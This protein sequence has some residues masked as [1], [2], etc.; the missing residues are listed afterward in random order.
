LLLALAVAAPSW[1]LAKERLV[2]RMGEERGLAVPNVVALGQDERG[3]IWIGTASCLQRHD[4]QELR[5]WARDTLIGSVGLIAAGTHDDVYVAAHPG[6]L[7]RLTA[8]SAVAV[9]GPPGATLTEISDLAFDGAGRLWVI[10]TAG[11]FRLNTDGSWSTPLAGQLA[12]ERARR[13]AF[14]ADGAAFIVTLRGLWRIDNSD[15]ASRLADMPLA[16]FNAPM[17]AV[18]GPGG[19]LFVSTWFGQIF[20]YRGGLVERIAVGG[21]ARALAVR[22]DAVWAALDGH[23]VALYPD[24]PPELL[25][26]ERGIS[27]AGEA[28]LVD[29][30]GSLWVGNTRGLFQF[31]EPETAAWNSGDGLPDAGPID[32]AVTSEGVWSIHWAYQSGFIDTTASPHAASEI[33]APSLVG[34]LCV[35]GHGRLWGVRR[36]EAPG[37]GVIVSRRD[38]T[39]IDHAGS[40]G[41]A[42]CAG[43]RAG[44]VWFTSRRGLFVSGG[45]DDPLQA[46]GMPRT[47]QGELWAR[48]IYE[49]PD[50]TLWLIVG[51]RQLC[52]ASADDVRNRRQPIW[53]CEEVPGV[54]LVGELCAAPS[55]ALWIGSK[56]QGVVRRDKSGFAPIAA[57]L[58]LPS[59]FIRV[60]VAARGGGIWVS[61]PGYLLRVVERDDL[62]GGWQVVEELGAFHGMV[63]PG[64]I[65]LAEQSDG[66]LWAATTAGVLHMPA[67][68]RRSAPVA[69]R[70]VLVEARAGGR[71]TAPEVRPELTRGSNHISLQV[72]GLLYRDPG[73]VLY[74][75]RARPDSPWSAPT[76]SPT[77]QLIDLG[78]GSYQVEVSATSDGHDWIEPV[79]VFAFEVAQV[80]YLRPWAWGLF[81]LAAA[82]LVLAAHRVR[83]A[84]AA[85]LARQRMRIAMDLH[86]EM[87]SGLGSI[88][89]L[90]GMTADGTIDPVAQQ[91]AAERIAGVTRQLSDSLAGIVG[92][93]REGPGTLQAVADHVTA[94]AGQLFGGDVPE[95]RAEI[96]DGAGEVHLSLPV[97]RNLQ[98]IA[99]EA[100]HNAAKYAEAEQVSLGLFR[101]GRRWTMWIEDDGIGVQE[102]QPARGGGMGINS[103]RRRADE[104]GAT[105]DLRSAIGRNRGTRVSV[106]F[107]P[108]A[109]DRRGSAVRDRSARARVVR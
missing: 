19:G 95:F 36:D 102:G 90:A 40:G 32:V 6:S 39:F 69:P 2:R 76:T 50:G 56:G 101:R 51:A 64:A 89:I 38:G 70:I 93:L 54:E 49:D 17:D 86:D 21:V 108:D 1:S 25:P 29:R 24:R 28:L 61:G 11:V 109:P 79:R 18:V 34:N 65:D 59:R 85:R 5:H 31:P 96:G 60:L 16:R 72:S 91:S 94:R 92:S 83:M 74:R 43:G 53:Q 107:E 81:V 14:G 80:W 47:D 4:G 27:N 63:A 33:T 105:F 13:I 77:F 66:A 57:S 48:G 68:A 15:R 58:D 30:E 20:E 98:M 41:D 103:M 106:E 55:G 9:A 26:E 44:S 99:Y 10:D 62:P 87:G 3:F 45:G 78:P 104:I 82:L 88:R 37:D 7:Y 71:H 42:A 8:D 67:A 22:G 100:L 73:A 35:D 23:L 97:Q 12:D 46:L 52:R 75:V 84:L